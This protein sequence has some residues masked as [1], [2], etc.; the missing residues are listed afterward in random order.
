[1]RVENVRP[2]IISEPDNKSKE[3]KKLKEACRD[4]EAMFISQLLKSM[5]KTVEKADLYG[6]S[7]EE[8]I[9]QEMI[10]AEIA[11]SASKT[12]SFGIADMLYKQLSSQ[13]SSNTKT[14]SNETRGENR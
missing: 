3:D 1:M 14:N 6:S 10:D 4:F 8:E 2:G 7:K 12:G 13:L 5:R 11:K 9:W